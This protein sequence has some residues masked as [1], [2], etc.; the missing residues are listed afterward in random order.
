MSY[1]DDIDAQS[2]ALLATDSMLR[3][4]P[5]LMDAVLRMR[6]PSAVVATM[7]AVDPLVFDGKS[8][9]AAI[10]KTRRLLEQTRLKMGLE[11]P[12]PTSECEKI[13]PGKN[14][15]GK[16]TDLQLEEYRQLYC[17]PW[18]EQNGGFP[19]KH[20]LADLGWDQRP[21]E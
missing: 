9:K 21:V 5:V 14:R 3:W 10:A 15:P 7:I 12:L 1:S 18:I 19:R 20:Q 4:R 17:V 11:E 6:K 13:N 2:E 16:P 8:T